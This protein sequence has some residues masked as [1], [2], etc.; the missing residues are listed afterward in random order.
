MATPFPDNAPYNKQSVEVPGTR[1]PG[2]SGIFV[3]NL[4]VSKIRTD[5]GYL[6]HYRNGVFSAL[7]LYNMLKVKI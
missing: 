6:G 7:C 4:V 1:R 3:I 2:E 5:W